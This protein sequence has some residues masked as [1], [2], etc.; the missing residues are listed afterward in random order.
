MAHTPQCV[1][2]PGVKLKHLLY[3]DSWDTLLMVLVLDIPSHKN[4]LCKDVHVTHAGS[5]ALTNEVFSKSD[6]SSVILAKMNCTGHESALLNCS[7]VISDAYTC[8]QYKDAGVICQC[9][10][11]FNL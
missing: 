11:Q 7:Y 4:K 9:I 3:A 10:A 1:M 8:G 2:S 5:I 6:I